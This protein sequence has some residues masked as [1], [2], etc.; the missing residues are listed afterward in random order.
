MKCENAFFKIGMSD[1]RGVTPL[2]WDILD[3]VKEFNGSVYIEKDGYQVAADSMVGILSLALA[4]GDVIKV[5]CFGE[6]EFAIKL[7][8]E[9]I[10][11]V[12]CDQLT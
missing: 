1:K 3:C 6:D 11:K 9:K 4:N 12:V 2:A 8:L 5:T 10:G 7:C